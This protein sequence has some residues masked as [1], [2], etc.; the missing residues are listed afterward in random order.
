M[1]LFLHC[2]QS[3]F[4]VVVQTAKIHTAAYKVDV[5]SE[6]IQIRYSENNTIFE[7]FRSTFGS[8]LIESIDSLQKRKYNF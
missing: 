2:S 4:P 3:V 1:S 5:A 8:F 6:N 7:E